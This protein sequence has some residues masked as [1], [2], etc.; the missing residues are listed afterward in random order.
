MPFST[1]S[2]VPVTTVK[3]SA[4]K[5][6]K[7]ETVMNGF[8]LLTAGVKS[9]R[10]GFGSRG[11]RS[12]YIHFKQLYYHLRTCSPAVRVCAH[13]QEGT[14]SNPLGGENSQFLKKA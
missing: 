13:E 5:E 2:S 11:S 1:Y 10:E 3:L 12:S 9:L 14:G 6:E 8:S 4:P 7:E